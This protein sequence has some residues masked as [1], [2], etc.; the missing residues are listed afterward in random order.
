MD[1]QK[2]V[3]PSGAF[4]WTWRDVDFFPYAWLEEKNLES[5]PSPF[6]LPD[7]HPDCPVGFR[8]EGEE[9]KTNEIILPGSFEQLSLHKDL[10][11][12]LRRIEK[13]NAETRLV[14]N[15]KGVLQK[16]SPWFLEQFDEEL[17]DFKRRM[18]V[19]R[20]ASTLS[21]YAG[22]ELLAVHI[23]LSANNIVYYLGCWWNREYKTAAPPTFLLKRDIEQAIGSKVNIY[24]LGI[25]GEP[26]KKQ[27]GVVRRQ[28]KYYAKM[29]KQLAAEL[30]LKQYAQIR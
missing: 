24:D 22:D 20:H 3:L 10:F 16:A 27:W 4:Y 19:W 5:L 28:T 12:D 13:K 17:G 25:G 6:Y 7:V 11:K 21:A 2:V 29:S 1:F 15:E 23:T 26:Y 14:R 30:M 18:H 9:S 8:C